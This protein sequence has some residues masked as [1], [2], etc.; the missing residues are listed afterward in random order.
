MEVYLLVLLVYF[1]DVEIV[2]VDYVN[3]NDGL[4]MVLIYVVFWLL[5]CNGLSL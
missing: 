2:V 3:G 1:V 4:L 5:V